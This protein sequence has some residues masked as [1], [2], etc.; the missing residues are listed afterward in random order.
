MALNIK[1]YRKD[2][3]L[4][5]DWQRLKMQDAAEREIQLKKNTITEL[6]ESIPCIVNLEARQKQIMEELEVAF[7]LQIYSD[8]LLDLLK[9]YQNNIPILKEYLKQVEELA[10]MKLEGY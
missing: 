2:F 10:T 8:G 7:K 4:P 3:K 1:D 6:R 9:E 5:E